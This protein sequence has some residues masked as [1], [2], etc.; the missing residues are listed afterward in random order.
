MSMIQSVI[1]AFS[2]YSKIPMPR[3]EWNEKNMRYAFCFFPWVGAVTGLV[4][5]AAGS[6]IFS[7]S[8]TSIL[9]AVVMTLIPIAITG[10]I[11]LDGL[12]DTIDALSSYG[13]REKK[14][15][16]LKDPHAGAFA[17]VGCGCYLLWSLGIWSEVSKDLLPFIAC[18]YVLSRSLS[19]LSVVSFKLA[20]NTGLAAAFQDGSKCKKVGITMV[21]YMI[22]TSAVMLSLKPLLA[23]LVLC[24]AGAC[25]LYYKYI[26]Y[27]KFGGIT[28]DLA[29]YFLQICE[30]LM[31]TVTV[32]G[33]KF[34]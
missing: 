32:L 30:L 11:H 23:I 3:V 21:G 13:E 15:E 29:G 14:L 28:G 1:I 20:K 16:I 10:G 2:M 34:L 25:F 33:A 5:F 4:L 7:L 27:R 9:P 17:I 31:L 24:S 19:G 26:S 8:V 22:L 18:Q 12:L 6:F